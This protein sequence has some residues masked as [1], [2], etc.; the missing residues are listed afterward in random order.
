MQITLH[1]DR[2]V[3][4]LRHGPTA[5][6]QLSN[7][8]CLPSELANHEPYSAPLA[9]VDDPTVTRVRNT[10]CLLEEMILWKCPRY[11]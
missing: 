1:F 3:H 9:Y 8:K 4:N 5:E 6:L 10:D 2:S 11:L 7:V